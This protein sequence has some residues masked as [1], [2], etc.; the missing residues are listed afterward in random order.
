MRA[1][2]ALAVLLLMSML[3]SL[4]GCSGRS[5][6]D[7]L[8][9]LIQGPGKKPVFGDVDIA[10]R[11]GYFPDDVW[12]ADT[13]YGDMAYEHYDLESLKPYT[14]AIYG[15]AENG[16]DPEEYEEADYQLWDQLYYVYTLYVL[17]SNKSY[18]DAGNAELSQEAAYALETYYDA[19]DQ[20][21]LA[22][23][24]MA[25]SDNRALMEDSY[26]R[27]FVEV[28]SA[29]EPS[30]EEADELTRRE[31]A[32]VSRYYAAVAAPEPDEGELGEIF[33]ELVEVRNA[34]ARAA[35]YE[36]YAA[37]AYDGIYI[38]DY[39]PQDAQAVWQGA[40]EYIAPVVW[41][42]AGSVTDRA[43][44]LEADGSFDC[45]PE[46]VLEA[47]GQG[48]AKISGEVYA[49]YEYLTRRGLYDIEPSQ[50]KA[51]VG[52]TTF[53]NYYNEPFIFNAP[54]GNFYD[55][56]DMMHEFGHFVNYFYYPSGLVYSLPDNDLSELQ[57]QGMTTVMTYLFDD[58]F[59][60]ERGD[61]MRDEVLLELALA[62]I[63]GALYDEFQ[64]RVYAEADLT[65]ERV[66]EIY[67]QVYAQYGYNTYDGYETEWMYISHNF[68]S[69]F[70]YISYAVSALGALEINQLCESD[71]ETGVD[72]Y[73]T[74]LSM[75]PEVWYYS[76]ALKDAGLRDIFDPD[77]YAAAARALEDALNA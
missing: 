5:F 19:Y 15:F 57:S 52:F 61:V 43:A 70:Y 74:V 37:Y 40:R 49:A 22:L 9:E 62:V 63:D 26:G 39:T 51:E 64:Q 32:L 28:V 76:E 38:K 77:T 21:M 1:R 16:G 54:Y 33:V 68:E 2:R 47:L 34:I 4:A 71:F 6:Y 50:K 7:V 18:A 10:D 17:A 23:R 35:G 29:Y 66:N 46:A 3:L 65:P 41:S 14:D 53:L 24:A 12:R 58:I 42:Y 25:R 67:A 30:T 56:L 73:L 36:S 48:A 20:F 55:Y 8:E 60:P 69:P 27:D 11:E 13:D 44:L 75:D 59:G 31:N 45:S 72:K